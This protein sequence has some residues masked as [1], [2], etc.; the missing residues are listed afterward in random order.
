MSFTPFVE[1]PVAFDA[2]ARLERVVRIIDPGVDHAAIPAR[3]LPAG[4]D[5]ALDDHDRVEF[6]RKRVRAREAH[7][8]SAD[9]DRIHLF[10][11]GHPP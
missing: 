9:Y 6:L 8:P 11:H 4:P 5:V 7:D 2:Q 1:A 3:Y 10:R